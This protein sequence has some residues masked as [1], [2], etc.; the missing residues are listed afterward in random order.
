VNDAEVLAIFSGAIRASA[1]SYYRIVNG[2]HQRAQLKMELMKLPMSPVAAARLM[3]EYAFPSGK[4]EYNRKRDANVSAEEIAA[5]RER[6]AQ[7]ATVR[8][9]KAEAEAMR[10]SKT[11]NERRESRDAFSANDASDI[12]IEERSQAT[13]PEPDG[14]VDQSSTGEFDKSNTDDPKEKAEGMRE[15]K[16]YQL[17]KTNSGYYGVYDSVSNSTR[18]TGKTKQ[19]ALDEITMRLR[20]RDLVLDWHSVMR[21][22]TE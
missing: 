6:T 10:K 7:K 1:K 14:A 16:R 9:M 20:N 15:S 22:S 8:A 5:R 11:L 4:F 3:Q 17:T 21:V 2:K 12:D 13:I 18:L 19:S